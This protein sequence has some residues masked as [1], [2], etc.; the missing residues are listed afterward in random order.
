MFDVREVLTLWTILLISLPKAIAESYR[1]TGVAIGPPQIFLRD[2]RP[3]FEDYLSEAVTEELRRPITFSLSAISINAANDSIFDMVESE[4]ADFVYSIPNI[5]GCLESEFNI[6]PLVTIRKKYTL[7]EQQYV[8]NR[9][10]LYK[11]PS[12]LLRY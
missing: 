4:S 11:W 5:F 12:I 10:K 2:F 9:S 3:T 7:S 8:L 1:I 6:S